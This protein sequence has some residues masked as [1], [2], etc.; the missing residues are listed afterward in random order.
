VI[1]TDEEAAWGTE[2]HW[3][4]MLERWDD[5]MWSRVV[6]QPF[7][8]RWYTLWWIARRWIVPRDVRRR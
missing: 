4:Q 8:W 3:D 7:S 6:R 1:P 2:L 5:G